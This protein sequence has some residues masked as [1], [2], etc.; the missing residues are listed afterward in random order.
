LRHGRELVMRLF[1]IV[2]NGETQFISHCRGHIEQDVL[3][4]NEHSATAWE[5]VFEAVHMQS[6]KQSNLEDQRSRV[7]SVCF[8]LIHVHIVTLHV[9]CVPIRFRSD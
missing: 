8:V 1:Y 7:F 6:P 5:V 4:Q 2:A 3:L 9:S